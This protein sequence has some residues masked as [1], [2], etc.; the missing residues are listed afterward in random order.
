MLEAFAAG[1]GGAL[2]RGRE[3][4]DGLAA[5]YGVV[6]IEGVYHAARRR[7]G[8]FYGDNAYFD[9][10]RGTFYRFAR[11]AMQ[12]SHEAPPDYARAER[13]GLR[14]E[15]WRK[16]GRYVLLVEQS[17]HYLQLAGAHPMWA[18]RTVEELRRYTDREVRIRHW[19]RDKDNAAATLQEDLRDAWA[20]VTHGSGAATEALVAGVPVFVTMACAA[21]PMASGAL[22]GIESPRYPEGRE[23]WAAG[24]AGAQWTLEELRNGMAWRALGS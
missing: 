23:A 8:W 10:C 11:D 20:L 5:F 16:G 9:R 17:D 3:L 6:G 1:A 13:L 14:V 7:G 15:P 19:R 12:I 24:L 22:S 21:T 18:A 2:A 4:E